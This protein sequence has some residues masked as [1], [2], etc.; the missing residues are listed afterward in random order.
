[1]AQPIEQANGS[2]DLREAIERSRVLRFVK[3]DNNRVLNAISS[4]NIIVLLLKRLERKT[5]LEYFLTQPILFMCI[6][7][8]PRCDSAYQPS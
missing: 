5:L 7:I 2:V 6:R 8:S 4:V 3:R 1:M